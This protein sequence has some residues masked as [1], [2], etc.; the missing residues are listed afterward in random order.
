MINSKITSIITA[1]VDKWELKFPIVYICVHEREMVPHHP[2]RH[3][4]YG[5]VW[6]QN[7]VAWLKYSHWPYFEQSTALIFEFDVLVFVTT[8]CSNPSITENRSKRTGTSR[9]QNTTTISKELNFLENWQWKNNDHQVLDDNLDIKS[10]VLA[11][12]KI[13]EK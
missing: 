12:F 8:H 2:H 1:I 6:R 13:G 3:K 9:I 10:H 4:Q 5:H 11:N 7:L